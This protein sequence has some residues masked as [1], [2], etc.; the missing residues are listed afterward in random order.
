MIH[1][2]R[3]RGF[4]DIAGEGGQAIHSRGFGKPRLPDETERVWL[5]CSSLPAASEVRLNGEL[6]VTTVTSG[7]FAADITDWL[8][9]RNAVRIT[10]PANETPGQV[11]LEIRP[12]PS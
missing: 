6:I 9:A 7:P 10:V 4:W 5:T 11:S 1:T 3:L 2:I 8:Q 12:L